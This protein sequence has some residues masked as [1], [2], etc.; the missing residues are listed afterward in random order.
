[1]KNVFFAL[2]FMLISSFAFASS[3]EVETIEENVAIE[4]VLTIDAL[5]LEN[6]MMCGFEFSWETDGPYGS[7]SSWFDCNGWTMDDIFTHILDVFF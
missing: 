5:T 3:A 4:N 6:E 1:M 2:A 7:G